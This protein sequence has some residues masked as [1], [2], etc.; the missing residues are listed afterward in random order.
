MRR[1]K[2]NYLVELSI[3]NTRPQLFINLTDRRTDKR[4]STATALCVASHGK[5]RRHYYDVNFDG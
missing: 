1:P 2:P 4:L 5:N 3:Q